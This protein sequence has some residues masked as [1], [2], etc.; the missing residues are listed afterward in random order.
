MSLLRAVKYF[1]LKGDGAHRS[2]LCATG[3]RHLEAAEESSLLA[4]G[5]QRSGPPAGKHHFRDT[6]PMNH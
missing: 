5:Q 2:F 6:S 1:Q 3:V 4:R